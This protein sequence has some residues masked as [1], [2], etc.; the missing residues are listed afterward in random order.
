MNIDTLRG[1]LSRYYENHDSRYVFGGRKGK[2]EFFYNRTGWDWYL[3]YAGS[4]DREF[5]SRPGAPRNMCMNFR[6]GRRSGSGGDG[7]EMFVSIKRKET[8]SGFMDYTSLFFYPITGLELRNSYGRPALKV[9]TPSKPS[10]SMHIREDGE[11]YWSGGNSRYYYFKFTAD[12]NRIL[13]AN[14]RVRKVMIDILATLGQDRMILKDIARTIESDHC[15]L[16][17]I[18]LHDACRY[19]TPDEMMRGELTDPLPINYNRR[20]MN[21]A[22]CVSRLS[23]VIEPADRGM[24]LAIPADTFMEWIDGGAWLFAGGEFNAGAIS[25]FAGRYYA[26]RLMQGDRPPLRMLQRAEACARDYARMCIEANEYITLRR[27]SFRGI[28]A[29]HDEVMNIHMLQCA[30]SNEEEFGL[31]LL[32][33]N[34]RFMKLKEMLP[35]EFIMI[36]STRDLYYEGERQHNCVFSYRHK[37][38]DDEI[39]IFHWDTNG[40]EYTIEF[41]IF[42]GRFVIRQMLRKY[43]RPADVMDMA[44]V[45]EYIRC[46]D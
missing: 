29:A 17:P 25:N 35:D 19:R 14:E 32:A 26:D 37:V 7:S 9:M 6:D 3:E 11:I 16:N 2:A 5:F 20:N 21:Y 39:A 40:R 8:P 44:R 38:R 12:I 24:L 23:E 27:R 22:W 34:S 28:E 36:E 42:E 1:I 30:E 4:L 13:S 15:F 43:N 46:D 33:E 31:P 18:K 45:L 41:G 10:L